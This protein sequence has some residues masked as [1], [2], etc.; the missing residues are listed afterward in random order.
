MIVQIAKIKEETKKECGILRKLKENEILE[1][2]N[3]LNELKKK[4][5]N[6]KEEIEKLKIENEKLESFCD[7]SFK[8]NHLKNENKTDSNIK[9]KFGK[10][11]TPPEI[12]KKKKQKK[13]KKFLL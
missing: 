9:N 4:L 10:Y 3:L 12:L 6:S 13:L 11:Y 8:G 5:E 2:N 7:N 1:L